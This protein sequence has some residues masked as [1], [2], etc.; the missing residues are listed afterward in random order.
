M[1]RH[2]LHMFLQCGFVVA[3][4]GYSS[5]L[6]AV[7]T[8]L[9]L[10]M[11]S[12]KYDA[13]LLS[14]FFFTSQKNGKGFPPQNSNYWIFF[15]ELLHGILHVFPMSFTCGCANVSTDS[16][17]CLCW[18][19]K[20]QTST[21]SCFMALSC[22]S[23]LPHQSNKHKRK[24]DSLPKFDICSDSWEMCLGAQSKPFSGDIG[25]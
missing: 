7:H 9:P 21:R 10:R 17:Q 14:N 24:G 16:R 23:Q 1:L 22:Q 18:G 2:I 3:E 25:T 4:S 20:Q 13:R 15:S 5:D 8:R 12:A 19:W 11:W 6:P